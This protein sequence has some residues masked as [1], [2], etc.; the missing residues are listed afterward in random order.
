M[1]ATGQSQGG[2]YN[3]QQLQTL[4]DQGAI[5]RDTPLGRSDKVQG[6]AWQIRGLTFP[7]TPE[8]I[9]PDYSVDDSQNVTEMVLW[10][11]FA[12]SCF[13]VFLGILV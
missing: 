9:E 1:D 11:V 5:V 3:V 7:E 12:I 13:L 4:A 2:P 6:Y 8:P 10:V